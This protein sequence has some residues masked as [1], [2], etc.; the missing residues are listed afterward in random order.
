MKA[1]DFAEMARAWLVRSQGHA[2]PSGEKSLATELEKAFV[3]GRE[4]ERAH[5]NDEL[6]AL[7]AKSSAPG[8]P[9]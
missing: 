3:L 2:S 8:S 9:Q 5:V 1:P 6:Q 7:I 4:Y